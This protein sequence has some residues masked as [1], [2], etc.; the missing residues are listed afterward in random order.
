MLMLTYTLNSTT[1]AVTLISLQVN[2]HLAEVY[3][4][5]D[6]L[7]IFGGLFGIKESKHGNAI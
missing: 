6:G 3:R 4:L 2:E 1:N 5:L 7:C